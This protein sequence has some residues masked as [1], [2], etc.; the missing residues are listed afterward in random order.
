MDG[1]LRFDG[2]VVIVTGAGGG[3]GRAYALDLAR[4]GAKV[5][6]NDL[7]GST[8][9]EGAD[10][11]PASRVVAEIGAAGGTAAASFDSVATPDGGRAIVARALDSWG[12]LD[13]LISNAGILRDRSFAKIDY[14]ETKLV[15]DVHL[16][17]GG[18]Y[19]AQPAFTAMK[20]SG[21]AGRIL[22]T[23]SAS[24]LFGNFGQASYGAA[25]MGLVGLLRTL[26]IE[27]AKSGIK[28]NAIAPIAGTRLTGAPSDDN[29]P[30]GPGKVV[31]LA[32]VLSHRDCPSSGEIYMAGAGWF[33]RTFIGV[34]P[35]W[36]AR[37]QELNAESLMANWEKVSDATGYS[38]PRSAGDIS[39][40]MNRLTGAAG[41]PT[42]DAAVN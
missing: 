33:T 18:F 30:K 11:A 40:V 25:K 34:A 41:R 17:G 14:A 28:V 9:G 39:V 32:V 21:A 7:G 10:Q 38:E 2:E 37:E 6:V 15:F 20:E 19:V 42:A 31:P 13:A 29:A 16:W 22:L 8:G 36:V 3:L 27:G 1:E 12:R 23:T 24:G 5:L 4:R 26:S 35:G